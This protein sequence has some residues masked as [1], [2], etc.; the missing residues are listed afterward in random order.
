M[1]LYNIDGEGLQNYLEGNGLVSPNEIYIVPDGLSV[2]DFWRRRVCIS[3]GSVVEISEALLNGQWLGEP[4]RLGDY[5]NPK[6][7]PYILAD[8]MGKITGYTPHSQIL[9]E[10]FSLIEEPDVVET[11]ELVFSTLLAHEIGHL[12]RGQ[13][14]GYLMEIAG[15]AIVNAVGLPR[16]VESPDN[17]PQILLATT[18]LSVAS[19][20]I[21]R[22]I[23]ELKAINFS[24]DHVENITHFVQIYTSEV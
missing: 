1:Y 21:G 6:Q 4:Q 15:V 23:L 18:I 9:N 10:G 3:N 22:A 24:R 2:G 20:I 8:W 17:A 14:V 13:L 16:M 19:M 11:K 12:Q 5:M 7:W